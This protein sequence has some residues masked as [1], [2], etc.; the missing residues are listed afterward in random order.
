MQQA[1]PSETA[2]RHAPR[3]IAP[4]L[5]DFEMMGRSVVT[6]SDIAAAL[7]TSSSSRRTRN[8]IQELLSL[9]GLRALPSRGTYEFLPA[10]GGPWS[11]GDPLTEARAAL[12]RRPDFR[13]AM[14]G[15][16]AAFLR[17]F[18]ERPPAGYAVAIDRDQGG[19][20]ALSHAY[21][22]VKTTWKRLDAVPTLDGVP[23]SDAPRLLADAALWPEVCGDLRS[24]DHWLSR[25]LQ[26]TDAA[27]A[28]AI[29]SRLGSA[30]AARM[31]YVAACFDAGD[32]AAAVRSTLHGRARTTIGDPGAPIVR[33]D[34]GLGVDDRLGVATR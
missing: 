21:E 9:G 31:A 16:G 3:W 33:R 1:E 18:H 30:V 11:A 12:K 10:R 20:V 32:V 4:V 14:V 29:A 23:V 19:S 24:V 25:S 7:E 28:A 5:A 22:I 27:A 15:T 26:T 8:A 17:G 6:V 13:L 34:P 2:H